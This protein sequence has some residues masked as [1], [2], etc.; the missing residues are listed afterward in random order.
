MAA[1]RVVAM[2]TP[3]CQNMKCHQLEA[4]ICKNMAISLSTK[5]NYP[6]S[7]TASKKLTNNLLTQSTP[8]STPI[9]K[10]IGQSSNSTNRR[11]GGIITQCCTSINRSRV[12]LHCPC[13]TWYVMVVS[14]SVKIMMGNWRKR[15]FGGSNHYSLCV[16]IWEQSRSATCR[17]RRRTTKHPNSQNRA[18]RPQNS[19]S[20][21][22]KWKCT[23]PRP[24]SNNTHNNRKHTTTRPTKFN[25]NR[26]QSAPKARS[27]SRQ[28]KLGVAR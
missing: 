6:K 1:G 14:C 28:I 22:P 12:K 17:Q 2:S 27:N 26:F 19:P 11:P 10:K 9:T 23:P 20:S 7:P 24:T 15:R 5:Q 8:I 21:T 25:L 18:T 3:W 16:V 13:L 4:I